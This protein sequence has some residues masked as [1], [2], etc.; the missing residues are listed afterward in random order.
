MASVFEAL[1]DYEWGIRSRKPR[2]EAVAYAHL[3]EDWDEDWDKAVDVAI[4][5]VAEDVGEVDED[6]VIGFPIDYDE[7]VFDHADAIA[8]NPPY[9]NNKL[10][11]KHADTEGYWI[12]R[13]IDEFGEVGNTADEIARDGIT[14]YYQTLLLEALA[15]VLDAL[16]AYQL[17][18]TA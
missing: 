5:L 8:Y 3:P 17:S 16:V 13:Y 14:A 18:L 6:T 12:Q 11:Q 10:W 4:R 15:Q 9:S 7:A 1:A 2:P